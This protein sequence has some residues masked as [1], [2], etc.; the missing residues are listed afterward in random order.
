MG[1]KRAKIISRD[2]FAKAFVETEMIMRVTL[3]KQIQKIIDNETNPDI[4]EGLRKAQQI[5]F[6]EKVASES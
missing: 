1:Q 3:C 5:V 4:I 2:A 6:G